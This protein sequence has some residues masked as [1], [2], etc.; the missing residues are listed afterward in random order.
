MVRTERRGRPRSAAEVRKSA[1]S[2]LTPQLQKLKMSIRGFSRLESYMQFPIPQITILMLL[3]HLGVGC[4][5]HHGHTCPVNC[6][7]LPAAT[8]DACPCGVQNHGAYAS[9]NGLRCNDA[10]VLGDRGHREHPCDGGRCVF[11]RTDDSPDQLALFANPLC[12]MDVVS[13]HQDLARGHR[14]LE[15]AADGSVCFACPSLRLHLLLQVLLI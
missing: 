8:A 6:Y 12:P 1:S 13:P 11:V 10:P 2:G 5:W 4:C 14:R 9:S 7:D 15:A 3:V